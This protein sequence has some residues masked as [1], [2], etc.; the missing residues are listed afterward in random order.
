[1]AEEGKSGKRVVGVL[2][3]LVLVVGVVAW[4]GAMRLEKRSHPG[5]QAEGEIASVL[6]EGVLYE[7]RAGDPGIVIAK[8]V[9]SG[10]ELWRSELGS[11]TSKPTLSVNEDIIEV[12]IAET[13]W[14]IL[15]KAT[16]EPLE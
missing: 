16:G 13:P 10:K 2:L 12:Q 3:G 11:I 4:L 15:D 14:M 5:D 1:M 8:D 7:A 6:S 9:G